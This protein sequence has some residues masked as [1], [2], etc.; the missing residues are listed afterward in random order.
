MASSTVGETRSDPT[1]RLGFLLVVGVAALVFA[2]LEIGRHELWCV[3]GYYHIRSA[4][5]L[6]AEGISRSFPWWQE[7]FL[8]DHWADKDFLYHLLLIPF[9]FGALTIGAKASAVV[10]ATGFMATFYEV[11]RRLRIPWATGFA[12][13]L[14]AFSPMLLARL[15]FPR[16]FVLAV[17][18]ALAGT[19]AILNGKPRAA[20]AIAAVYSWTHVSFHLLPCIALVHDLHRPAEGGRRSFRTTAFTLVGMTAGVVLNPFFPNNLRLWWVQNINVL[21]EAWGRNEALRLGQE[22]LPPIPATILS[23]NVGIFATILAAVWLLARG[24]RASPEAATLLLVTAGF[25]TLSFYSVVFLEFAFPFGMLFAGIVAR[26]RLAAPR[27]PGPSVGLRRAAATGA[28]VLSLALGW[29]TAEIMRELAPSKR[30]P[31]FSGA[32]AYMRGHVPAGQTLFHLDWDEF[33][34]LFFGNPELRFLVGLDPTFMLATNPARW[35]LYDDIANGRVD[36]AYAPIRNDFRCRWVFATADDV[37]FL[38]VARRDPR[39]LERYSDLAASVFELED[40]NDAIAAWR[41][42]GY[43]PDPARK[44]FDVALIRGGTPPPSG[45]AAEGVTIATGGGFLDLA[46]AVALPEPVADACAVAESEYV[47]KAEGPAT[48]AI[49]SDDELTVSVNGQVVYARSPLREP[50][51]GLPGGPPLPL[52]QLDRA[53]QDTAVRNVPIDVRSGP[54][55]IVVQDCRVGEDFGFFVGVRQDDDLPLITDRAT[56]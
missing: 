55:R 39:F 29:R 1:G 6:R 52:D 14:M 37:D 13:A 41:V 26:D 12:L 33:P 35:R 28:I 53:V 4:A 21:G 17:A 31:D 51:A 2:A 11:A 34:Q 46:Q 25:L 10:F 5:I 56:R 18:L 47:A 48:L 16:G 30:I 15:A 36:D 49:A 32:S 3:D 20:G 43:W 8:R 38:R 42:S 50:R 44:L 22:L 7:T 23:L 9:T 40:R 19:G 45:V 54:N 24:T 27:S